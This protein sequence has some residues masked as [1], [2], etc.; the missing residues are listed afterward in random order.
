VAQQHHLLSSS[1]SLRTS[2]KQL[3]H[4]KNQNTNFLDRLKKL[5]SNIMKIRQ[6]GDEL[7]PAD[8]YECNIIDA[9]G[10]S[11]DAH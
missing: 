1:L 11:V 3:I 6:M 8:R 9:F 7:F 4:L 10:N 5:K 2:Y